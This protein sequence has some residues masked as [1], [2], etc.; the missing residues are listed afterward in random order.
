M[1][2][3]L[4]ARNQ[5]HP[6][7]NAQRVLGEALG[8]VTQDSRS[9]V[10]AAMEG[11]EAR[12]GQGVDRDRVHGEIATRRRDLGRKMGVGGGLHVAARLRGQGVATRNRDVD[13]N[14]PHLEDRKRA[15]H[16]VEGEVAGQQRDEAAGRYAIHLQVDLRG[17][18]PELRVPYAAPDEER[19]PPDRVDR[20]GD[21]AD[22]VAQRGVRVADRDLAVVVHS[23]APSP[24]AR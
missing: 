7:Q 9:E 22:R 21:R 16:A 12:A 3:Q 11:I 2:G 1:R 14:S 24:Q 10:R 18:P 6:P 20:S 15:A 17:G 13:G 4:E 19:A 5:L 8:G 23:C